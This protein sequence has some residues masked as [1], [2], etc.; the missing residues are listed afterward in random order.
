MIPCVGATRRFVC[1]NRTAGASRE[2]WVLSQHS[3]ST[4]GAL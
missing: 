4:A 2:R 3:A 1:L